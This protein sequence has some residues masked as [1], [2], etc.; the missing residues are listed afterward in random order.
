MRCLSRNKGKEQRESQSI[1]FFPGIAK[2][3]CLI[4][5]RRVLGGPQ[6]DETWYLLGI[7]GGVGAQHNGKTHTRSKLPLGVRVRPCD[8]LATH[9][10]CI[11]DS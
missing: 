9:P 11:P 8:G 2:T 5:F 3:W 7:H 4:V 10:G 6:N 1:H